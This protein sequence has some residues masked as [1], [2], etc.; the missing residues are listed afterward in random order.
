MN[1]HEASVAIA[2]IKHKRPYAAVAFS[3]TVRKP[4]SAP[5]RLRL[6]VIPAIGALPWLP[7]WFHQ[8]SAW[9]S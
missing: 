1:E 8:L 6:L 2:L 9:L 7:T 4:S 3:M 5:G